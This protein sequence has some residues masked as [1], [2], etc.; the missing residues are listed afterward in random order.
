[1]GRPL[2]MKVAATSIRS[3]LPRYEAKIERMAAKE[4]GPTDLVNYE[5]KILVSGT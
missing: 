2:S 3:G 1:M 5:F 4:R